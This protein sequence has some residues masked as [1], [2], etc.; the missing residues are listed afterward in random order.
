MSAGAA[1]QQ[2]TPTAQAA[3]SISVFLSSFCSTGVTHTHSPG[4]GD[5]ERRRNKNPSTSFP[6]GIPLPR[7]QGYLNLGKEK[8]ER[9]AMVA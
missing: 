5:G 9:D 1:K 7:A 8:G 6:R 2:P 3:D 4:D